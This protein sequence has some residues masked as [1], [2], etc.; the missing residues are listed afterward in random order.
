MKHVRL[1]GPHP[2]D[3]T[4]SWEFVPCRYREVLEATLE[5]FSSDLIEITHDRWGM[6]QARVFIKIGVYIVVSLHKGSGPGLVFLVERVT[7]GS[8]RKLDRVE[9][10]VEERHRKDLG[11]SQWVYFDED[12]EELES[13]TQE[14][15]EWFR[16]NG[17]IFWFMPDAFSDPGQVENELDRAVLLVRRVLQTLMPGAVAPTLAGGLPTLQNFLVKWADNTAALIQAPD[18]ETLL[19]RVAQVGDM[20]SWR[21]YDGPVFVEIVP[22]ALPSHGMVTPDQLGVT[23]RFAPCDLGWDMERDIMIQC[24]PRLAVHWAGDPEEQ[25]GVSTVW[26]SCEEEPVVP[27]GFNTAEAKASK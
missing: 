25:I 15:R 21:R 11:G 22:P 10:R 19:S 5:G 7:A 18:E 24:F 8:R 1:K 16:E 13:E 17:S 4:G 26:E 3:P 6:W 2:T 9:V 23:L 14:A 27:E 20:A 12:G